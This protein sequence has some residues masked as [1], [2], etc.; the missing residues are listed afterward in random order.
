QCSGLALSVRLCKPSTATA[1]TCHRL[2]TPFEYATKVCSKYSEKVSG[3][4]GIG[5]QLSATTDDKDR[6]C[7]IGCQDESVPYRFYMVNGEE[8][9]F[10]AGTDCS[11]GDNSKKAYC[12]GGKCI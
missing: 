3:L 4:S 7:R 10:P 8:G 5:M 1:L 12:M 2:Q 6:P 9:W 11:R